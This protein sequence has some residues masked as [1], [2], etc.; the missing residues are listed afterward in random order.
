MKFSKY[1]AI[2]ALV[3]AGFLVTLTVACAHVASAA[4]ERQADVR[5]KA[6]SS[7]FKARFEQY[8]KNSLSSTGRVMGVTKILEWPRV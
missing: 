2:G 6:A 4:P 3:V 1:T 5:G 7:T 8:Q